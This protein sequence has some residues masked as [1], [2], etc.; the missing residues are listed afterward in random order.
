MIPKKK[1]LDFADANLLA[2]EFDAQKYL[3]KAEKTI[4]KAIKDGARVWITTLDGKTVELDKTC[5]II[6]IKIY[7]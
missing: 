7:E 6:Y 2:Y 1:I 3:K 5:E 4:H